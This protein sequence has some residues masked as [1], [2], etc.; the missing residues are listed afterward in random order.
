MGDLKE[1]VLWNAAEG[2]KARCRLCNHRCLVPDNGV[3]VCRVRKNVGGRLYSLNYGKA[4]SVAVDPVE[5]KPFF[6]WF[7]GTRVY[8]FAAAGCNFKCEGC[9]NWQI[10]QGEIAGEELPPEEI[11]GEAVR[12]Q[13]RGVAYTYTEPTVF[14]EYATDTAKLAKKK[15][16]YNVFVTNG[17]M[18][19]E[20]IREMGDIDASR[21]DLKFMDERLYATYCRAKGYE[22]V[23]ESIRL[24]H[25]KGH[26]EVVNLVIPTLN[27]G[28][29]SFR[30]V[31]RFVAD[32]DADIPLHFIAFYPANRATGIP[33]T[34]VKSLERARQIAMGEGV[35]YAY[36]GNVPGH[37]GENTYCPGCGEP[38]IERYG[39]LVTAYRL[40]RDHRCPKC[41][42]LVKIWDDSNYRL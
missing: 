13:A 37:P 27:D 16:L 33:P 19:P 4:V 22:H 23:L 18:T 28:E 3:G 2:G 35:R 24:L 8:S 42:F 17:Y 39:F 34:G 1:A 38:V 36:V 20:A 29:D 41:G 9:Q 25:G 21:I 15:H 31:A 6:H 11:A 26:V 7:P 14:F 12:A 40:G 32:L 5:K 10:S 30:A